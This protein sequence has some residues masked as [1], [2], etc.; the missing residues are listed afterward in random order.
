MKAFD[1]YEFGY[2]HILTVLSVVYPFN[3]YRIIALWKSTNYCSM[4][5]LELRLQNVVRLINK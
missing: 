4:I 5:K 1:K 3:C 2:S